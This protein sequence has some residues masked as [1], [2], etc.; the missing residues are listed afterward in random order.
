M[1]KFAIL[2]VIFVGV[3]SIMLT[4]CG[5]K[6]D[7]NNT[8]RISEVTHSIFYAPMYVAI[9]EGYFEDEGLEIELTN[10]GGSDT[11]MSSL[12]SK[13]SDIGLMGPES[14]VYVRN[15]GMTNA[16]IIFAQLTAC[17]GSFLVGRTDEG[18]NFSWE[19]LKGKQHGS[20]ATV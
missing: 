1:K 14:V 8:I 16:P 12:I 10:A 3:F 15:N 13:S 20:I 6:K 4:G 11:V 17:D 9:N 7:E 2:L 5:N 18:E 19:N